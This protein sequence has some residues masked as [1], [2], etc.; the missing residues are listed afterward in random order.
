MPTLKFI[1][2]TALR[3]VGSWVVFQ[4][5][6]PALRMDSN[7][8][9]KTRT[10]DELKIRGIFGKTPRGFHPS[11]FSIRVLVK[12]KHLN[13]Q[14]SR[15]NNDSAVIFDVILFIELNQR[16][17]HKVLLPTSSSVGQVHKNSSQRKL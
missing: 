4:A 17:G 15:G 1:I 7:R 2:I 3:Q 5:W 14:Y 13:F 6:K 10:P 11:N 12:H 8:Q 9:A 16:T